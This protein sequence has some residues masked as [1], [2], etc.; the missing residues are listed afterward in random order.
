MT[1]GKTPLKWHNAVQNHQNGE[2]LPVL[3]PA[4]E[5]YK[6]CEL[7]QWEMCI[8][9]HSCGAST[10]KHI[11]D[12]GKKNQKF[13]KKGKH[14]LIKTFP[15]K[16][17]KAHALVDYSVKDYDCKKVSMIFQFMSPIL[18]HAFKT[19]MYQWL[20]LNK[21]FMMKM[22]FKSLKDNAA[23]YQD[24][25]NELMEALADEKELKDNKFYDK[26]NTAKECAKFQ[27]HLCTGKTYVKEDNKQCKMDAIGVYACQ[28][29]ASL[30]LELLHETAS[31]IATKSK[32]KFVSLELKFGYMIKNNVEHYK[33]LVREQNA[34]LTNYADFCVGC[35]SKEMLKVSVSSKTVK[36]NM[37]M[38]P[39]IVNIHSSIYTATKGIWTIEMTQKNLHKAIEDV[40]LAS[41][42]LPSA[43]PNK[44][45]EKFNAFPMPR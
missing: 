21:I 18:F 40:E 44:Y 30:S 36:D 15:P 39:Y 42:A 45:F 23:Q 12:I 9:F 5:G 14:V 43:V 31:M 20:Q 19:A 27:I 16:P 26:H 33:M 35:I 17:D 38:L 41:Q 2:P 24:N 34:Y 22:I 4:I 8:Q 11:M 13:T 28:Q 29:F 37:L 10:L 6:P 7:F 1:I 32:M 25:I 3:D